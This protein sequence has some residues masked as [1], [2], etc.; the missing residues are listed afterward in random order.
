MYFECFDSNLM[1]KHLLFFALAA[2][3]F[4]SCTVRLNS[5]KEK[6]DSNVKPENTN[7][8]AVSSGKRNEM[9]DAMSGERQNPD[10]KPNAKTECRSVDTGDKTLLESQ[11]FPIDFAPFQNSCFVTAHNPEYDDPPLDSEFSIY[12]DGE[13]A[14]IFPDQFNGVTVGCWVEAVS[15]EDLNNDNLTDII[16]AGMCSAKSAP[17]AENMVYINNGGGFNT[18]EEANYR[19]ADFKKIKDISN[20]VKQNRNIF[21]R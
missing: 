16:V 1:K 21:F 13:Q 9:S 15:F 10:A 12:K 8:A 5:E 3:F 17:Y 7:S 4:S 19:L 18:S 14:F 6:S 20:F 2:L 11:T